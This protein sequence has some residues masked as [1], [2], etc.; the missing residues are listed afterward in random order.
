I[1]WQAFVTSPYT[2][3]GMK[4][5]GD[6]Q[7]NLRTAEILLR[8]D[9]AQDH[10]TGK[11][12]PSDPNFLTQ[13]PSD[14]FLAVVRSTSVN[15]T[16]NYVSEGNGDAF[17][18]PS[19]RAVDQMIYMTNKRK[20]NRL[21]GFYNAVLLDPTV[22]FAGPSPAL[23]AFF[24]A[25]TAYNTNTTDLANSTWA[26]PYPPPVGQAQNQ[27][28]Y[29]SQWAEVLYYLVRTGTTDAPT[30]PTALLGTPTYG[31]YRAQF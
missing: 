7:M 19:Y 31:L 17:G 1:P 20:G 2:F 14:G 5:I 6:M 22:G 8:E 11:R 18:M 23:N 26:Q 12:R 15:S 21:E 9:L 30:D 29:N 25:T 27:A 4:G 24:S 10:F 3:T 28:F 13:P 16:I